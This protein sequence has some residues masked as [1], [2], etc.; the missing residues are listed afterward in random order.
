MAKTPGL[1][2]LE[3]L[4]DG[5]LNAAPSEFLVKT[6][7]EIAT[8]TEELIE[9]GAR[10]RPLY[11][12]KERVGWVRGFHLSEQRALKRWVWRPTLPGI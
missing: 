5:R 12:G 10:I 2:L 3:R 8:A 1:E 4:N 9:V 6:R 7:E 11:V